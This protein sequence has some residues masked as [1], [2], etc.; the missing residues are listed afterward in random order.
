MQQPVDDQGTLAWR[1]L[2][3]RVDLAGKTVTAAAP[4]VGRF[5]L[6]TT[7]AGDDGDFTLQPGGGMADYQ[8][9]L[10]MGSATASYPFPVPPAKAGPTPELALNYN[11]LRVDGVSNL[12][13]NQPGWA[14]IGWSL[15]IGYVLERM[16]QT[17]SGD[18]T[19]GNSQL[20]LVL[21]GV[22]GRLI[23]VGGQPNQFVLQD[24]PR[25][26]IERLI[27]SNTSHPDT[28]REYWLVTTPDGSKYRFGG[29]FDDETGADLNSAF[30][31]PVYDFA[32]CSAVVYR[33]CN[34]VWRWNLDRVEDSNGNV[35]TYSYAQETNWYSSTMVP[36]SVHP[37]KLL[38]YVRGGYPVAI[39]YTRRAGDGS[40]APT[41]RV[42]FSTAPRCL[43][44]N[45]AGLCDWPDDY[46]D[47]P[48][49]LACSGSGPCASQQPT[50]WN[51][52]RLSQVT[53]SVWDTATSAW[54]GVDRWDLAY[55]FPAPPPYTNPT[56]DFS[57]YDYPWFDDLFGRYRKLELQSITRRSPDGTQSLPPVT[58]GYT[59]LQ[60]RRNYD[61]SRQIYPMYLSRLV[62]VTNELGGVVSFTYASD[63]PAAIGNGI[64]SPYDCFKTDAYVPSQIPDFGIWMRYKVTARTVSSS[65]GGPAQT[66]TYSYGPH[67]SHYVD[68]NRLISYGE[69]C[70]TQDPY[71]AKDFWF[72][73]RGYNIVTV[74][75]PGG[76]V[77]EY[78][79]HRGMDGDGS[80]S[81]G[82]T[83]VSVAR[84]DGT[85]L[86]DHNWLRG[87][88][89]EVRTWNTGSVL[90]D[91]Q[92]T[93]YTATLTAG[94][95]PVNPPQPP[96]P[97]PPVCG[98]Y[99]DAAHFVAAGETRG[100]TYDA[101]GANPKETRSVFSYD[102]Y[103]NTTRE[104]HY[105][106]TANPADDYLVD[107]AFFANTGAWIVDRVQWQR[108]FAGNV[109]TADGT[110]KA[111]AAYG[112]D[113][114]ALFAGVPAKGNLTTTAA[115]HTIWA[116]YSDPAN[117]YTATT[118]Y[119]SLGRPT[120][121]TDANGR[122][123]TTSYHS[124]YG[125]AETVSNALGHVASSVVDPGT[126]NLLQGTDPNGRVTSHEY[127]AFGRLLR[128]WLPGESQ[129]SHAATVE[130][131]YTLGSAGV[132]SRITVKQRRDAGGAA[133]P[134]YIESW[135]FFDEL[136]RPIQSQA[137]TLAGQTVLSNTRYDAAGQAWQSSLAYEV[138][139][140]PGSYYTP[141]WNQPK[142]ETLYDGLGRA[143]QVVQPAGTTL[144][145]YDG[146]TTSVTDA[147]L[148]RRAYDVDAFGRTTQVREYTGTGPY[149]LYA[150]T[151]YSYDVLGQL[152]QVTDAANNV[153]S[154][155][156][157]PL[158]RKTGMV[159]PDMGSWSYG[160]DAVGN[161]TSQRDGRN[162]WLYFEYD[163][164]NRLVKKRQDSAVGPTIAEYL[165]D[166]TG[167][168]GLLS[169]SKAYSAEGVVEIYNVTYDAR[170]RLTQQNWI[171]PGSGGGTFRLDHSYNA[172]D[173]PATL[174]YPGGTAGQQGELVTTGYNALGQVNSVSGSGVSYVSSTIYNARGQVVEQRLDSGSNGLTRQYVYDQSTMRLTTMRA[175]VS[176]PYT[177]LQNLSY[178]YDAVGNIASLVDGV[179]SNQR[180]CF[181]YDALDRLTNAFTGNSGCTAYATGGTGPYNH[182]YAYNA[183]GNITSYAGNAYSYNA[184]KPHA[185]SAAYGNSY[186][187]DANGNQ[188]TRTV[189]GVTYML[190]FDYENR[191]TEVKQG[192][193][194][195]ATFLYDADGNRVKGTVS[196]VT[197]VYIAGIYERQGAAAT[198]YY[199]G[200]GLRRSGYSTNNGVFYM[201]SDHLKSTSALV[202]RNGVLNVKYFYYPYGARRGVP[203]NSITAKRF[204]GQ[205][206]EASLPGGEGLSFYN[207]RWYDPKLGSF[208]SADSIV[209]A[210]LDPQSFNRYAYAGANPLR[211]SDPSGHTKLCGAACEDEYKWSPV[212]KKGTGSSSAGGSR[213]GSQSSAKTPSS[214]TGSNVISTIDR[215]RRA[216]TNPMFGGRNVARNAA[217]IGLYAYRY[218]VDPAMLASIV[219][220]E[221]DAIERLP[222]NITGSGLLDFDLWKFL[223]TGNSSIGIGQVR[224]DTAINLERIG[225]VSTT[226]SLPLV[227]NR[228]LVALRLSHNGE[229]I[230]YVAANL[231]DI[232]NG[233]KENSDGLGLTADQMR[234][235]TIQGYNVGRQ[236]IVD[237]LVAAR[238]GDR[239]ALAFYLSTWS[240]AADVRRSP[241]AVLYEVFQ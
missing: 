183:I 187:Y 73:M 45:T 108:V 217:A 7:A 42:T 10:A 32:L 218:Q 70:P 84:S 153:T 105:G 24:D 114:L 118:Q 164:L 140:A 143:T 200:G 112:Y 58:F 158:G 230:R 33:I 229:N 4:G 223:L 83:C 81:A 124:V 191:L 225:L 208:L 100:Y 238:A 147:N 233:V 155:A 46:P 78:R 212:T 55:A 172:A 161:L 74:T 235:L 11:S 96:P 41:A 5:M 22:D 148:H 237:T 173:Q 167:Q 6:A 160:Y 2:P 28:Q 77:T 76:A 86:R 152:A 37:Y 206:H 165:F 3:G 44:P 66:T 130:A 69:T 87:R 210:P 29:E 227:G 149:T 186:G 239:S 215:L 107:R 59:F 139:G 157:D 156:Y 240:Y 192:T 116:N 43:D 1:P 101:S 18:L 190:V 171:V 178:S 106:D 85:P 62:S 53:T 151:S 146:W 126:G 193:T 119:D 125:Y 47:T 175:G 56:A 68:D 203:F 8:V 95:D 176:S 209:P 15:E 199:E 137:A 104:T 144:T 201:L 94:S 131:S 145:S 133:T 80:V 197:T 54:R 13:N 19:G 63:C 219:Y 184:G 20:F 12:R 90:A 181:Q 214:Q 150:T 174:R 57:T 38:H 226:P 221:S 34:Q 113:G 127:D 185:V 115:Y 97:A 213:N 162:Q 92:L 21:N 232:Q 39:E 220:Y 91:R 60:N 103:G 17:G 182:I 25:W 30:Y 67:V 48:A 132:P 61:F 98:A 16:D 222:N 136:G 65:L 51:T 170:N 138:A 75:G 169:R 99:T 71:C 198:S 72:E 195:L 111:M 89:Y 231:Q 50:F 82:W 159:D 27:S 228:P 134:A 120:V 177:N 122:S 142:S 102:G 40:V 109:R 117:F 9:S 154:M 49:D 211:F 36:T 14:G 241:F 179:N 52:Q 23:P 163:A 79:Y 141:D 189:S 166:A 168:K 110:E 123:T 93:S 194:S 224:I 64:R 207:A 26:R 188:T 202:A 236:E 88:A 121:S 31:V 196:G 180:Q 205:Y 129:G 35:I 216:F 204:T 128:T 234:T 135:R